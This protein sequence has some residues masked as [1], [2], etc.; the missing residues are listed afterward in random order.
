MN[1]S[2]KAQ[3][4][5]L[6]HA[7]CCT[8]G[9]HRWLPNVPEQ[10]QKTAS[11]VWKR[12]YTR[13][14]AKSIS[15]IGLPSARKCAGKCCECVM[16]V[17]AQSNGGAQVQ[18]HY[19]SIVLAW[20]YASHSSRL[21]LPRNATKT[22]KLAPTP[23]IDIV[24]KRA[25]ATFVSAWVPKWMLSTP[26]F[27]RRRLK[28]TSSAATSFMHMA[29]SAEQAPHFEHWPCTR[30]WVASQGLS[31]SAVSCCAAQSSRVAQV[32]ETPSTRLSWSSSSSW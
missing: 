32:A 27:C 23:T 18:W 5:R 10:K 13:E 30:A 22:T 4:L 28:M 21:I 19:A 1:N 8:N 9:Q 11:T 7:M 26:N 12:H 3:L 31:C 2:K 20:T 29:A 17:A 6:L 15:N 14:L 16:L 24:A 25:W